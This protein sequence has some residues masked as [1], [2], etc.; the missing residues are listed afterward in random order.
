MMTKPKKPELVWSIDKMAA[1]ARH[2]GHVFA[3]DEKQA[4]ERA[5]GEFSN[6]V[7][8]RFRLLARPF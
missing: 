4:I 1:K 8:H 3:T 5:I 6:Q 2:V 7:E